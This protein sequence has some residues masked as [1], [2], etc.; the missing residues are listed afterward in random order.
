[1]CGVTTVINH[2]EKPGPATDLINVFEDS[3]CIHSLGFEKRWKFKLNNP[4]KKQQPVNI[5]LGE[6][7]DL[8]SEKEVWQLTRWNILNRKLIAV[9][10][11]AMNETQA[12]KFEAVVW[13]PQSNYFLLNKT[14]PI[15]L[16]KS[17]TNILF[18]TDST[19]TSEWDIWEHLRPA[20]ESHLLTGEEIYNAVT[21]NA[22][23]TWGL[24]SGEI[25]TGKHADLVVAKSNNKKGFEAFYAVAPGDLLLVIYRGE[26]KLFDEEL[27]AQLGDIKTAFSKIYINGAGK[28]V[29]GDLPGLIAAVRS[30]KPD[31][32]FPQ[33]ITVSI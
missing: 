1:L 9:H 31:A 25:K 28:Y 7:G 20:R 14:A 12:D 4:L 27:L 13:C 10:A 18:G 19:L 26:I 5:H 32:N 16:L 22:A 17:H 2:D 23:L 29:Q 33:S 21:I 8:C 15:N 11:V 24:N 30:Y 6:G 3:H